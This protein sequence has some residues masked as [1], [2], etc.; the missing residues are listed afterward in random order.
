MNISTSK[1]ELVKA[2]LDIE[3]QD[4]S[5]KVTDFIQKEKNDFWNEL[6]ANEQ[7]EI[8]HGIEDLDNGKRV[9]F[10][11]FLK[12]LNNHQLKAGGLVLW[13][14]SPDT[15]QRPVELSSQF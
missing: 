3:N 6:T 8:M 14:E 15:G 9:S 2:I 12:K 4:F 7:N 13:T 11:A 10:D 5:Q 1:I